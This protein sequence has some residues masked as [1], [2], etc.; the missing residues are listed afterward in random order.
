M[1]GTGGIPLTSHGPIVPMASF[2][3]VIVISMPKHLL[4]R[5]MRK[6]QGKLIWV[7]ALLP[8][9][10]VA[11]L[12]EPVVKAVKVEKPPVVDG[13]LDDSCWQECEPAGGFTMKEPDPGDPATQATYVYVAYDE[14]RIYFGF[15][16]DE[17]KPRAIAAT[18][19]QRDGQIYLDDS[20]EIMLDTYCDRRNA[21]YFM[22]N[23]LGAKL[24]GR[25]IDDGRNTD[26]NWDAHWETKAQLAEGGWELE[27]AIPFAELSF[28]R[29]DSMVW[30]FNIW[31]I[32]RPHWEN[33]SWSPNVASWC[34]VSK[35]GTLTGLAVSPKRRKFQFL[36]YA[37]VRYMHLDPAVDSTGL[38]AGID[39][40]YGMTSDLILNATYSPDFAQIEADPTRFN[41]SYQ[42]GEELYYPEK[43]PFFLEGGG[44]LSTPFNLFY[45]RRMDEILAGGKL[46][47]KVESLELLAL[48]VQTRDTEENFSVLR[49]KQELFGTA[50]LGA[51]LT[52]KQDPSDTASQAAGVDLNLPVYGPFLLTSQGAVTHNTGASGDEW[53][54]HLGVQG[55]TSTYGGGVFSGRTGKDFW[56][57][58]GFI[59]AYDI[60]KQGLSG[61][62]WG[63]LLP[64]GGPLQ[65]I[66]G[67]ASFDLA[68]E[69]DSTLSEAEGEFWTNLVTHT[70]WRFGTT[71]ERSYERYGTEEFVNKTFNFQIE[72]N[73]GGTEG[74][75]T[76]YEFGEKYDQPWQMFQL[77][78]LVVPLKRLS[79]FP[80][81]V[82]V[83][84][85]DARWRWVSNARISCQ[86]TDR[87]FFRIFL[88]A[89]SESGHEAERPT[90]LEN[91]GLARTNALFGYEYAPGTVFYLAYNEKQNLETEAVDRVVVAKFTYSFWL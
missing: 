81:S 3:L 88:E 82:A 85:G 84:Q 1:I 44:I 27:M 56:V 86:V 2:F 53:A 74:V 8:A 14:E 4:E 58:Q 11:Q 61:Y 46:Y 5:A 39:F 68:Q 32:E 75:F 48:D 37:A 80:V 91:M 76:L 71:A 79:V 25:I 89:E 63:K 60:G 65:W 49:L 45:T 22:S 57:D 12:Q 19:N 26:A 69:I 17:A 18:V 67:G 64:A 13:K 78:F 87:A 7:A 36:P 43:R 29:A 62:G 73:V 50:S 52:H 23:L 72:S 83:K 54:G 35:Y 59:N 70:K 34:Q 47:G 24:D 33:T 16:L 15:R 90:A 51:L 41:L 77:G 9:V 42:E 38:R 40:E 30:G 6:A 10:A 66:D 28:A 31:R 21:Y 20:I 55:E